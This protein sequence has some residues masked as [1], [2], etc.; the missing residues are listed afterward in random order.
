MFSYKEEIEKKI[1][2]FESNKLFFVKEF[3]DITSYVTARKTLNRIVNER[4]YFILRT[5]YT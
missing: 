5:Y 1:S 4:V 2:D 3:L